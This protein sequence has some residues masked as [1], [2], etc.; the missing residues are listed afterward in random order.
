[1]IELHPPPQ[2]PAELNAEQAAV[3]RSLVAHMP[4]GWFR[5]ESF[6]MLAT[7]CAVT[8]QLEGVNRE[9]AK[10]GS[11]LPQSAKRWKH[12]K[13]LTRMR[14]TLVGQITTMQTKLRL[15]PQSRI[16]PV[17]AG[18]RLAH[19]FEQPAVKPWQDDPPAA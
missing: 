16:D 7:L 1:V 9:F 8:V 17:R 4:P 18:R 19:H 11:G 10:F 12:Y 14:G 2:P 6:A 5:P 13:D 3:W 15:T